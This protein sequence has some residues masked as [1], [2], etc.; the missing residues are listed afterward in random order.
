M[1]KSTLKK[2]DA[3]P[4]LGELIHAAVRVAIESAVEE[5]L[6][7]TLG[8]DAYARTEGRRGYRNGSRPRTLTGP[9]G[10]LEMRI[11][12]GTIFTPKGEAGR[13]PSNC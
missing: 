10:K 5:E 6:A 13:R 12:R 3:A 2:V 7:S 11:P 4:R 8:A 9:T 1:R